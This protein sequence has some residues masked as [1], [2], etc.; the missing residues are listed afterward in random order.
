[1]THGEAVGRPLAARGGAVGCDGVM[2]PTGGRRV[3]VVGGT[4][5]PAPEW[6]CAGCGQV[7]AIVAGAAVESPSPEA[8]A[9][10]EADGDPE[11][12]LE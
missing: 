3:G 9:E 1:M 2:R 6:S 4:I 12:F 11:A 8:Q 7:L 5:V 10:V